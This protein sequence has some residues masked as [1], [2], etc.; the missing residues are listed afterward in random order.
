MSD[1]ILTA[2]VAAF[3]V[4]GAAVIGTVASIAALVWRSMRRAASTNVSLWTYTRLLIDHIYR[5]GI[6][7]PPAPP[8]HIAHLYETGD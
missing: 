1:A 4:I 6:G 5:G 8:A 2:L 3:G 7:P